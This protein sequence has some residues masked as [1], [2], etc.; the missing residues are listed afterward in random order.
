MNKSVCKNCIPKC[1]IISLEENPKEVDFFKPDYQNTPLK[2]YLY[3]LEI[4]IE[5]CLNLLEKN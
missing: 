4:K 2:D 1:I 5:G 3:L